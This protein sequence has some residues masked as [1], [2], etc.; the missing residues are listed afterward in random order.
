[1]FLKL[2]AILSKIKFKID[3]QE[4]YALILLRLLNLIL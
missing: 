1:M 4:I 3:H 2:P